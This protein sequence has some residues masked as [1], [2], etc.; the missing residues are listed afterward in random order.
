MLTCG[1][2][3]PDQA[4]AS[5]YGFPFDEFGKPYKFSDTESLPVVR[6]A[7]SMAE[8]AG[9]YRPNQFDGHIIVFV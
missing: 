5:E 4:G 1:A 2:S 7:G 6:T 9:L 3:D 8:N